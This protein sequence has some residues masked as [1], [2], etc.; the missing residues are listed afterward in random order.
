MS[1]VETNNS[2]PDFSNFSAHGFSVTLFSS[3]TDK[4]IGGIAIP[5]GTMVGFMSFVFDGHIVYRGKRTSGVANSIQGLGEFLEQIE[6]WAKTEPS[7]E[8]P[9][10][11]YGTTNNDG[12]AKY[13]IRLGF[14]TMDEERHGGFDVIG[15]L[16]DVQKSYAQ[17]TQD[18]DTIRKLFARAERERKPDEG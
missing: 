1:K 14:S 18:K 13:A 16:D 11:L 6:Y 5:Q 17:L 7:F 8:K 4:V 12:L 15:R 9:V 3:G 2:I 10:Y